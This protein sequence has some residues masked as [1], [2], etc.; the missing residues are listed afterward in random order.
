MI[1]I[2]P[3]GIVYHGFEEIEV[4]FSQPPGYLHFTVGEG[5]DPPDQAG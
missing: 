5:H 2:P 3:I 4:G 1:T